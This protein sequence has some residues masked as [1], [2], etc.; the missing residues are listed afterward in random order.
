MSE[1]KRY[2]EPWVFDGGD[3]LHNEGGTVAEVYDDIFSSVGERIVACVNACAGIDNPESA[4]AAAREALERCAEVLTFR[5][6]LVDKRT[7]V[8]DALNKIAAALTLLAPER[9]ETQ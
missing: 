1:P 6:L 7:E 9:K 2:G 4:L 3:V 5:M 8:Q